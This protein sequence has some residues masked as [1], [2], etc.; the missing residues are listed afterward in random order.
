MVEVVVYCRFGASADQTSTMVG[1]TANLASTI[2]IKAKI[3]NPS[4]TMPSLDLI[5]S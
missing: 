2:Y 4:H 3:T 1:W 5:R